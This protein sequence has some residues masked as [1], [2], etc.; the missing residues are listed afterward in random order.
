MTPAARLAAGLEAL[1]IAADADQQA[2]LLA[3]AHLLLR[4][5]RAYNLTA[6]RD[7]DELVRRHLLDSAAVL[8]HLQGDRV[9]DVGTGAGLPGVPLAILRPGVSFWLL[10]GNGKRVRFLQ[11]L[12]AALPE[13]A[14]H[15]VWARAE[16][17]QATPF[18]C[19]ISRAVTS[20]AELIKVAG[21]LCAEDGAMLAMKGRLPTHELAALPAGWTATAPMRLRVPGL[22]AERHLLRLRRTTAASAR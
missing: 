11:Q 21:H 9:L 1:G 22:D 12:V 6:A 3:Y 16:L 17:W 8:P 5:N 20:A 19:V 4:W 13:L 15:P 18:P 14:I 7:L 10:D 2:A